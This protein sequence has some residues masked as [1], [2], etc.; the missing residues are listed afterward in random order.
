[1]HII[2]VDYKL[3]TFLYESNISGNFKKTKEWATNEI[4]ITNIQFP[5]INMKVAEVRSSYKCIVRY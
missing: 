1:M 4:K 3:E 5:I 2:V